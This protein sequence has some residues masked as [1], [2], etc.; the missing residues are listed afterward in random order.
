MS[1]YTAKPRQ[2]EY[3]DLSSKRALPVI[4]SFNVRGDCVPLYLRYIFSDDTYTDISIDRIIEMNR[5]SSRTT[6]VCYVTTYDIRHTIKLVHYRDQGIWA[7]NA[8]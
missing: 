4:A 3:I 2:K 8:Y 6:Y 5:G 1:F 7:L